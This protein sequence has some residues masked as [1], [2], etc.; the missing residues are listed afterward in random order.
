[1][2]G[3]MTWQRY[4]PTL[5]IPV[6]GS[7]V[8]TCGSVMKGP[9]SWGQVVSTGIEPMSGSRSTTS[10]TG[11]EETCF[12]GSEASFPSF[13]IILSLSQSPCGG[14][15]LRSARS[16]LAGSS[17]SSQESAQAARRRVPK[18]FMATGRTPEE[19]FSKRSAGP[20]LLG[21][22]VGQRRHV[23]LEVDGLGN[24][25]ELASPLQSIEEIAQG[26]VGHGRAGSTP[27][28]PLFQRLLK[29]MSAP[30][31]Q[32][33]RVAHSPDSDDA[34]MF[35]GLFNGPVQV[36]GTRLRAADRRHRVPEPRGAEGDATTSPPSPS[37]PTPMSTTS[38]CCSTPG[39]PSATAT[40]PP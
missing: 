23:E 32:T 31:P 24:A 29:D 35:C 13:G 39:P 20:L 26:P 22:A 28:H 1:M 33:I 27:F 10:W 3:P 21:G 18:R 17:R 25:D 16:S 30:M 37:P 4:M 36:R 5:R 11:P 34:F 7:R 8:M 6:S 12:G 40:G 38:T 14:A 19:G 15:I 9:P 2:R